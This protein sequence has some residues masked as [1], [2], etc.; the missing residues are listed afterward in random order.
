[1]KC[2]KTAREH[3]MTDGVSRLPQYK[4]DIHPALADGK[5]SLLRL[6]WTTFTKVSNG[7]YK[8]DKFTAVK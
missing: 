1:M 7:V 5:F 3:L 6:F 4:S 2:E 8:C